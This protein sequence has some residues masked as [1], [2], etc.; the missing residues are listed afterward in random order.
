[1]Q[2][3]LPWKKRDSGPSDAGGGNTKTGIKRPKK[4]LKKKT[5]VLLI[6]LGI[7]LI[8]SGIGLYFLF[9][10]EDEA[11]VIT[12]VTT[13]GSL[14]TTL[15]GTGTTVPADS[16]TYSFASDSDLLEVDVAAGDTVEVG[17]LLYVQDDSEIDDEIADYQEEIADLNNKLDEYQDS[18]SDLQQT[19]ANLT[20]TAPFSG[21]LLSV[22]VDDEDDTVK[23]GQEL[24]VLVDDSVMKITQYFSYA[25]EDEIYV[26]MTGKI[27]IAS[28]MLTLDATVTEISKVE[29]ITEEG[30][31]CFAVTME[32]TNPG[33]LTD[34]M[35][36]A[37]YLQVDSGEKLYPAVEGELEYVKSKTITAEAAGDLTYLNAVDYQKVTK[38]EKLFVI[39]GDS[40]QT[41]LSSVERNITSTQESIQTY[42]ERIEEAEESRE[43]Y[44]VRSE[45]AGKVIFV[46]AR[47]GRTPTKGQTAIMIYNLDTMQVSINIDELDI[48]NIEMGMAVKIVQS[49]AETDTTYEGSVSEISYEATNTNG[50][51]YF[52]ITVDIESEGALSAGVNVSYYITLGDEEEGVLAPVGALKSTDDG[53]C[54]MIQS[55]TRP[56]DAVDLGDDVEIP[57]GFYAVPV[58]TGVSNSQY[59]RIL[60]GVDEG[61]T[62][63]L[64]YQQNAPSN[65]STTSESQ[66]EDSSNTQQFPGG[67]FSGGPGGMSGGPGGG[68]SFSGMGGRGG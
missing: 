66:E 48:D 50:V 59:V 47:L 45:I 16:V 38:G 40:Y 61:V 43:S 27:S 25:Y 21:R 58:T 41:Q 34:G 31:K 1:M 56:D 23:N 68:G 28:Q 64:R 7:L 30:T 4:K 29:R 6:I 67:N 10:K 53:T 32:I 57:D 37:G 22:S 51:A 63:F 54:L 62:V 17:D 14:A 46:N 3:V 26:G 35:T 65:G 60:S 49:G 55:D 18:L 36:G 39:D 12:D 5:I 19:I 9:F 52:P 8:A 11:T 13:Y 20:I 24:A 33:S 44:T 2:L 15:E 42:Q